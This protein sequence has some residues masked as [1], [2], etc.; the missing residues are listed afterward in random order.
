MQAIEFQHFLVQGAMTQL[1]RNRAG[2]WV[3]PFKAKFDAS[4]FATAA[5]VCISVSLP[6]VIARDQICRIYSPDQQVWL[7]KVIPLENQSS[8]FEIKCNAILLQALVQAQFIIF[9]GRI[10]RS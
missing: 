6:C 5:L 4:A 7:R 10:S 9:I 2:Q 1:G 3:C 8:V